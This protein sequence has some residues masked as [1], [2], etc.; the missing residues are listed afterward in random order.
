MLSKF[1]GDHARLFQRA[2]FQQ[3]AEFVAAQTRQHILA[4]HQSVQEH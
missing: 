3:H 4:A 2:V 1:L